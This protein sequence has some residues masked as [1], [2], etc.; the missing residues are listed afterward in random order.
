MGIGQVNWVAFHE[1]S[2]SLSWGLV[3]FSLC[4]GSV[5]VLSLLSHH[6]LVV[7]GVNATEL[8]G[9]TIIELTLVDGIMMEHWNLWL[10]RVCAQYLV[11][12][13]LLLIPV[14]RVDVM[15]VSD[16]DSHAVV[17]LLLVDSAL[18]A[19]WVP[20]LWLAVSGLHVPV[21]LSLLLL[22]VPVLGVDVVDVTS[23]QSNVIIEISGVNCLDMLFFIFWN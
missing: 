13:I 11:S 2:F 19:H 6:S 9:H 5:E 14:L 7:L 10:L 22:V 16:L 1:L 23:L 12:L 3:G 17:K 4:L 8:N 15:R 20:R 21:P 18:V